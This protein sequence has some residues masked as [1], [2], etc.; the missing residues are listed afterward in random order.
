MSK[1]IEQTQA[2]AWDSSNIQWRR[3]RAMY[4]ASGIDFE[5]LG[6]NQIR[7][8]QREF[9]GFRI[10][11][12]RELV[13]RARSLYPDKKYKI[14][15][16]TFPLQVAQVTPEWIQE[17]MKLY[18]V[19]TKDLINQLALGSSGVSIAI[20]GTRPIAPSTKALFYYYFATKR[21]GAELATGVS[22]EEIAEALAIVK[23]RRMAQSETL[24]QVEPTEGED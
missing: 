6:D 13:E 12:Q 14:V 20:N 7:V 16:I 11:N 8:T 19:R 9:K 10:F 18:H 24:E 2:T 22:P 23:A 17:Q 15:P 1:E 5:E 21:L 3:S 4:K